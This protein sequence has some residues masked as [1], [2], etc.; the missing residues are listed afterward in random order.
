M[1]E[2]L[3]LF[4]PNV[5][6]GVVEKLTTP[7][8]LVLSSKLPK[9]AHPFPNAAWDVIRGSRS[10]AKPN[11]PNSEAHIVPQLGLSQE[12]ASFIYL[13]EKKVFSPTTLHWLRAP[14]SLTN[15]QKAEEA[16]L[17]EVK[18]LNQ[19]FDNFVEWTCWQALTGN[20]V[21]DYPDVQANVNFQFAA[22][23]KPTVTTSWATATPQNIIDDVTAW[24]RLITR[25][26]RV[27]PRDAYVTE[28]TMSRIFRAFAANTASLLSDRAKDQYY[29]QGTLPGFLQL[30][31]MTVDSYY[32]DDS[33]NPIGFLPDDALVLGN[34]T[35]GRPMELFEGP[36]ADDEAPVG[37]TGRFAKTWKEKDP[38]ARQYL[39]EYHF[40]PVITRPEQFVYVADVAP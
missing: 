18:D 26:G 17:R 11:V 36:T 3:S 29:A 33:G 1:P 16:V 19:R 4:E 32:D 25:D 27:A 38:S 39:L 40:L 6:A 2:N 20:I 35:D 24:K 31:W 5:L 7:E 13:R 21:L 10:V 12:T 30:N 37:F 22:S 8:T 34:F 28:I 15:K 23:H 9:R 14:G